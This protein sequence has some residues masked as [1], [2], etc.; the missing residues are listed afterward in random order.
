MSVMHMF[1]EELRTCNI[2]QLFLLQHVESP[3]LRPQFFFQLLLKHSLTDELLKRYS[4]KRCAVAPP[5]GHMLSL[6][7]QDTGGDVSGVVFE[8]DKIGTIRP[9]FN[10]S[11]DHL[12]SKQTGKKLQDV[13]GQPLLDLD[14][15]NLCITGDIK[16]L[17]LD[18]S[19]AVGEVHHAAIRKFDVKLLIVEVNVK[20]KE[21]RSRYTREVKFSYCTSKCKN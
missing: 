16:K 8:H 4:L 18:I 21:I 1:C 17:V 11:T 10:H 2:H 14:S 5:S 19:Q 15:H 7:C 6:Q 13:R 12:S 20:L 9:G 3:Y